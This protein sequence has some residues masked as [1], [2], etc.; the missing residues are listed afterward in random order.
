MMV[1]RSAR[2]VGDRSA[3]A[4]RGDPIDRAGAGVGRRGR[5]DGGVRNADSAPTTLLD[6]PGDPQGGP[7][8]RVRG[9][10][11]PR[12]RP[13]RPSPWADLARIPCDGFECSIIFN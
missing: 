8:P 1:R 2:A 11:T 9:I 3:R 6:E 12:R 5:V 13:P 10:A 4:E 7:A